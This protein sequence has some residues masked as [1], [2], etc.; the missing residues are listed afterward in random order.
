MIKKKLTQEDYYLS[1][2]SMFMR[3]TF[4]MTEQTQI[5]VDWIKSLDNFADI[6][7][8]S[9]YIWNQDYKEE[10]KKI[11]LSNEDFK[12]LDNLASLFGFKRDIRITVSKTDYSHV[13]PT[14]TIEQENLH[15][16]NEDMID[17][18]KIKI[19]QNNYKGTL[20]ELINLYHDKLGYTI[21]IAL[22]R[23]EGSISIYDS[24]HCQVYLETLYNPHPEKENSTLVE[25]S[26]NIQKLFKW[27]DLFLKSMGIEYEAL[28]TT[29]I[30]R[31][32]VLDY[33]YSGNQWAIYDDNTPWD[34]DAIVLG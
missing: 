8:N 12:P 18:I 9:Y 31:I 13:P 15:L 20:Q 28:L 33:E 22:T 27:S 21:Y 30:R 10:L 5:F 23:K 2:L 14:V 32:L 26:Q 25:L 34:E 19:I 17:I 1:K 24:A 11:V 6:S 7:L 29:D 16:S 4:G 3:E